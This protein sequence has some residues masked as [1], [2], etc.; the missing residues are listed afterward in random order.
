VVCEGCAAPLRPN[1]LFGIPI[2]RER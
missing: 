1:E 2:R